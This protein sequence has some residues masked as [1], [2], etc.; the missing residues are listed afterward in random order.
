MKA[1]AYLLRG[2]RSNRGRYALGAS[3]VVVST[4]IMVA[5]GVVFVG[6]QAELRSFFERAYAYD[7][8][9]S[10]ARMETSASYINASE[11]LEKVGG[12]EGVEEAYPLLAAVLFT[13]PSEER[14]ARPLVV[15]GASPSYRAGRQKSL[16]GSYDLSPGCA[17]LSQKAAGKLGL[18]PGETLSL[19]N[20]LGTGSAQL[21]ATVSGVA[22]LEGRFPPGVDEYAVFGIDYLAP[23][24]NLSGMASSIVVLIDPS[25]YDLDNPSDP[26]G[27]A[28]E[29]GNK[30]A[31]RLGPGYT[32]A[33]MKGLIIKQSVQGTSFFGVMV[34]V[35]SVFF[36]AVAGLMVASVL[37]LSVEDKAHDLAVLR[38]LGARRA[39]V[40]RIVLLELGLLLALGLPIGVALG[41]SLPFI[42]AGGIMSGARPGPIASTVA[43]QTLI[44]VGVLLLFS[45]K[46]LQRALRSSPVDA[47]RRARPLGAL[48]FQRGEGIDRR[49]P[50]S[51]LVVF[52]AVAY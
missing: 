38:L 34:Y 19:R 49:I 23:A 47:V 51:G 6:G 22:E 15:Y 40:G 16:D 37:N 14:G 26:V 36:P 10:A 31:L 52:V 35:F 5:M 4:M 21:N 11:A 41:A 33:S 20:L 7:F 50:L 8:E 48:R 3:S 28:F 43:L 24:L 29:V 42:L 1:R 44:S 46:P 18:R 39:T 25:L 12:V 45:I 32:V 30:I 27:R 17:V 13:L 2:V 9:V